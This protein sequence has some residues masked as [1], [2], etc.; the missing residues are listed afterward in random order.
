MGNGVG[1][2]LSG[3]VGTGSAV[4][5][6]KVE[7]FAQDPSGPRVTASVPGGLA[8]PELQQSFPLKN[9]FTGHLPC[10]KQHRSLESSSNEDALLPGP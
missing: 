9:Q 1:T 10:A 6:P 2:G 5:P 8:I 4:I 3:S 7:Y